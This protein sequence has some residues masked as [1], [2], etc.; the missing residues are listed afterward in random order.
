MKIEINNLGPIKT[1]SCDLNKDFHLIIGDNNIGKSYAI[2]IIYLTIK[3][4]IDSKDGINFYRF[5]I[6]KKPGP[7]KSIPKK[8]KELNHME[9]TDASF[10]F[11]ESL[12][13]IFETVFLEKFKNYFNGTYDSIDSVISLLTDEKLSIKLI[14]NNAEF[15]FGINDNEFKVSNIVI[16]KKVKVKKIK[17]KR[18]YKEDKSDIL[19]YYC[20]DNVEHFNNIF[21]SCVFSHYYQLTSEITD[22]IKSIHYLPASRSG[23]YQAL[24]AF[25]QIIAQLSKSRSFITQKIEIPSISV[26]LSDY[27]LEL[28]EIKIS[29]RYYE[30]NPI[31]KIAE[32]IEKLILNGK[33]EFDSQ[34]KKLFYTP[35]GSTLK[36]DI[37]TTSSMVSE[38]SPIVAFLR[39]VLTM[40]SKSSNRAKL[41]NSKERESTK[42]KSLIFIEEPEAHLHPKNQ[43]KLLNIFSELLECDVKII[44]TSHSNYIFNKINNLILSKKIEVGSIEAIL[45]EKSDYGSIAK[46]LNIDDL[47]IDD[48]NFTNVSEELYSEKVELIQSINLK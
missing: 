15:E 18:Y 21:F 37:R 30:N 20:A 13:A 6:G 7:F 39:H 28:S 24:T 17:Q 5:L 14:F 38:I 41:F 26:P 47:G 36:L 2:T 23:L 1:F 35:H 44:I 32:K 40:P 31:N 46:S 11:T 29:K 22:I 8:I 43:I 48:E 9:E 3:S 34:N 33:V 42:N 25:G 16:N 19:I 10:I 12:C 27:F 4:L 45:I